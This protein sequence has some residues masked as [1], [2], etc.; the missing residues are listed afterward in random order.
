MNIAIIA[1]MAYIVIFLGVLFAVGWVT[2]F[3]KTRCQKIS[4]DHSLKYNVC[5]KKKSH[6]GLHM[7]ASG[8][9]FKE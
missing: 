5:I 1:S 7:T 2:W 9:L 4:E 3:P 6:E 8:D